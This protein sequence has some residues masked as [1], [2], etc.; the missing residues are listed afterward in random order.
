MKD[1]NFTLTVTQLLEQTASLRCRFQSLTRMFLLE[2]R[3]RHEIVRSRLPPLVAEFMVVAHHPPCSVNRSIIV[4]SQQGAVQHRA[5]HVHLSTHVKLKQ[6]KCF[7]GN[8]QGVLRL[9]RFQGDVR[10]DVETLSLGTLVAQATD[11]VLQLLGRQQNISK[12]ASFHLDF[13]DSVQ[14]TDLASQVPCCPVLRPHLVQCCECINRPASGNKNAH[15]G[16]RHRKATTVR[17]CVQAVP[18]GLCRA[19]C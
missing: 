2:K 16:M 7:M 1:L 13:H 3:P 17:S 8:T 19:K 12:R 18:Q 9:P 5:Q 14:H 10:D 11:S 4:T 6:R 15:D